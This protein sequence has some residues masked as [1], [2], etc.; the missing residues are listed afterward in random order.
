MWQTLTKE[1]TSKGSLTGNE[2]LYQLFHVLAMCNIVNIHVAGVCL[3]AGGNNSRLLSLLRHRKPLG[4]GG[5]IDDA[6]LVTFCDPTA[7]HEKSEQ[8]IATFHC[9]THNQKAHRNAFLLSKAD[10]KSSRYFL[11]KEGIRFTWNDC[12]NITKT[13]HVLDSQQCVS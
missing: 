7:C 11:S 4:K 3:D 13:I 9:S 1:N 12:V 5:W 10:P 2:I 8:R 6:N